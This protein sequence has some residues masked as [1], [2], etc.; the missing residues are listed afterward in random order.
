MSKYR[1]LAE[2]LNDGFNSIN[3]AQES[4]LGLLVF[5]EKRKRFFKTI[6]ERGTS[7]AKYQITTCEIIFDTTTGKVFFQPTIEKA[8]ANPRYAMIVPPF[9]EE[10]NS[11]SFSSLSRLRQIADNEER[12][13]RC[14]G[15]IQGFFRP[16]YEKDAIRMAKEK[17]FKKFYC[18]NGPDGVY[19]VRIPKKL[20]RELGSFDQIRKNAVIKALTEKR[21]VSYEFGSANNIITL[22]E[23]KILAPHYIESALEQLAR[24]TQTLDKQ[25]TL[26]RRDINEIITA[27]NN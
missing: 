17:G 25:I 1:F 24:Y 26:V 7:E 13:F 23:A 10:D 16:V 15:E 27:L 8:A 3:Q 2:E 19:T 22:A 20:D 18:I 12:F 9:C 21:D 14:G 11:K 5:T 4:P 6:S